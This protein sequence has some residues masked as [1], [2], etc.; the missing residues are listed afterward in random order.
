[1]AKS[2]TKEEA[3]E[4]VDKGTMCGK[5]LHITLPQDLVPQGKPRHVTVSPLSAVSELI[6]Y[7]QGIK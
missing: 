3:K 2:L 5:H 1:M 6:A 7:Q 4:L